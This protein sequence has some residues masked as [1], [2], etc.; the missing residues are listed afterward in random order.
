MD[1]LLR[2]AKLAVAV[3]GTGSGVIGMKCA[4]C[5]YS[6]PED[7]EFCQYCGAKIETE[8]DSDESAITQQ[9]QTEPVIPQEQEPV[10]AAAN[11]VSEVDTDVNGDTAQATAPDTTSECADDVLESE[12]TSDKEGTAKSEQ[13]LNITVSDNAS[14]QKEKSAKK[15]QTYC[16]RCGGLIDKEKKKCQGCGKQYFRAKRVFPVAALTA[17]CLILMALNIVQYIYGVNSKTHIESLQSTITARDNR[18]K[19]M[20]KT[21]SDLQRKNAAAEGLQWKADA[22]DEISSAVQFGKL[23]YASNRFHAS[24]SVIIVSTAQENRK[25]TLT[26]NWPNGGT[27]SVDYSSFA[28][29]VDFDK[30][31][32]TTSTPMTITPHRA[33]VTTVTFSNDVNSETFQIVI[34]VTSRT[35]L[36][37]DSL[38]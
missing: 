28:A 6:V 22:F 23:G 12:E 21:T 34:V 16:K 4:K 25:F 31:S 8:T 26:A 3:G 29:T 35:N 15:K 32:W 33:G 38:K 9:E 13:N 36:L 27:V 18:I 2:E 5:G 10:E 7:S 17:L 19:Q 30:D 1:C 20:E 11:E 14:T 37:R 24:E